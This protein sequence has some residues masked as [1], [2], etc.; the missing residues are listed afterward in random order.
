M[1]KTPDV[2]ISFLEDH[3]KRLTPEGAI[4]IKKFLDLKEADLRSRG[5]FADDRKLYLWDSDFYSRMNSERVHS[6]DRNK[7]AEYFPLDK[8]FIGLCEVY[9][10][11]FGMQFIEMTHEQLDDVVEQEKGLAMIW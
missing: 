10:H 6:F 1:T 2:V 8:M 5:E 3:R 7:V 4:E 9:E 11:L